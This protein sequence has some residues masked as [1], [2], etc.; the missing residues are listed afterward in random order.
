MVPMDKFVFDWV[1][2][3]K[4][5]RYD[6]S[7]KISGGFAVL[8]SDLYAD[9]EAWLEDSGLD[10]RYYNRTDM[11]GSL[12][13]KLLPV[14]ES[15]RAS[16]GGTIWHMPSWEG[17]YQYYCQNVICCDPKWDVWD[18]KMLDLNL[19]TYGR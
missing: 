11:A 16:C 7:R 12:K 9:Y 17:V 2:D 18:K 10:D 3:K 15:T 1:R 4:I 8:F 6:P 14:L 5:E 19:V 13:N